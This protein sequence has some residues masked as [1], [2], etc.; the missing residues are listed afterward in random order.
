MKE[1]DKKELIDV[2]GGFIP[3]VIFGVLYSAEV[4]AGACGAAFFAGVGAGVAAA[5]A[6]D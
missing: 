4:V 3:L 6:T 2:E 1:L 5:I